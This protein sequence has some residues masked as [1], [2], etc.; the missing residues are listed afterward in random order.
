[1]YSGDPDLED[2]HYVLMRGTSQ[3]TA[4]VSGLAALL[5]EVVRSRQID[6]GS[7]PVRTLRRLFA[8]APMLPRDATREEAGSGL[9]IWPNLRAVLEDFA[10]DSQYR[11]QVLH[12]ALEPL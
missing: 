1:M 2:P 7:Q 9:P 8:S 11:D 6:L 3:A 12:G 4:V 5:L 10:T